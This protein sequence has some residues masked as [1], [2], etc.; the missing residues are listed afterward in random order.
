MT[1]SDWLYPISESADTWWEDTER[2]V[3]AA[4]SLENFRDLILPG[5]LGDDWW[6]I[7]TNFRRVEVGDRVWIYLS[8]GTGVIGL[9]RLARLDHFDGRWEINLD[10]DKSVSRR[11]CAN[12]YPGAKVN[13][14]VPYPRAT[15]T[16]L[17]D[18][19]RLVR[20]LE[21]AAGI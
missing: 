18:H 20:A 12:P 10:F 4:I 2:D 15:V 9:A 7:S 16:S 21:R 6:Y 14:H 17:N 13:Q 11:L 19:P 1:R 8:G 5:L 3:T